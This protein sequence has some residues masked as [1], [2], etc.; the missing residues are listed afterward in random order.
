[1]GTSFYRIIGW[2]DYNVRIVKF[3]YTSKCSHK[4][5]PPLQVTC[6]PAINTLDKCPCSFGRG[7]FCINLRFSSIFKNTKSNPKS[8]EAL[9]ITSVVIYLLGKPC[10]DLPLSE[11]SPETKSVL[12]IEIIWNI[13]DQPISYNYVRF[14]Y[15]SRKNQLTSKL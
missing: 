7:K 10:F 5:Q 2:K 11:P 13:S 6:K 4:L 14:F 12:W 3:T 9:Q 8:I 1:M 15:Q